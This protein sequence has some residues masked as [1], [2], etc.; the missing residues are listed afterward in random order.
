MSSPGNN[1]IALQPHIPQVNPDCPICLEPFRRDEIPVGHFADRADETAQPIFHA[2]HQTCV[3]TWQETNRTCPTCRTAIQR[4]ERVN[5]EL[6]PGTRSNDRFG[7]LVCLTLFCLLFTVAGFGSALNSEP[8]DP[9]NNT[10]GADPVRDG[11]VLGSIG[12]FCTIVSAAAAIYSHR[13]RS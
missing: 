9:L 10:N 2:F 12:L 8:V 7:K 1:Y 13:H 3:Q 4:L 11:V 6:V 5:G